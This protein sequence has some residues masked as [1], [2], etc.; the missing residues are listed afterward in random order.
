MIMEYFVTLSSIFG[1]DLITKYIIDK[2]MSIDENG[3]CEEVSLV[4][5][6]IVFRHIKND[7]LAYNK[8]A[9]NKNL[10]VFVT[11]L[12]ILIYSIEFLFNALFN[13]KKRNF[14]IAF[15]LGGAFG[16]FYERIT[17]GYVTDFILI[18]KGKN[19]PI[20]NIADVSLLI[21]FILYAYNHIKD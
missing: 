6:T 16:N 19:P 3:K 8:F 14:S 13:R 7:G 4:K 1:L 2:K 17:K 15:I 9:G 11:G 18:K 5:N 21:G 20:F 10:I 12:I